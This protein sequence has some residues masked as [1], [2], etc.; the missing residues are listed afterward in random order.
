M[1]DGECGGAVGSCFWRWE[2]IFL[3]SGALAGSD[4]GT[5]A[6]VDFEGVVQRRAL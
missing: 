6:A 4:G 3:W 1:K 5:V 2:G